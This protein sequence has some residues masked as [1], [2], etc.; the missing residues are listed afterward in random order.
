MKVILFIGHHKVGSTSLQDFLAR[1]SIALARAGILYPAT[2]FES[3]S[4][5]LAS[6]L[7]DELVDDLP[8][9]AR[10]PHNAL[11]FKLMAEQG[12]WKMPPYHKGLPGS[13]QMLRSIRMQAEYLQPHTVILAAE[14]FANFG[15]VAPEMI[16]R[17]AG[18]L[19]GAEL[20]VVATFRRID[21]YLASW[22]GQRLRFGAPALEPLR[23]QG[24]EPYFKGVHFD[25][26][27]MLE[28]WQQQMPEARFILRDYAEVRAAGGA[29]ADFIAQTGLQL[30]EG[31]QPERKTN[32]SFHR[33]IFEIARLGNRALTR[34]QARYLRDVLAGI[35]PQLD[36]PASAD[37]DLFGAENRKILIDRFEPIDAYLGEVAGRAGF[38]PDLQEARKPRPVPEL[39]VFA[40]AA[41]AARGHAKRIKD[42]EIRAFLEGLHSE[43]V[44]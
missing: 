22:F 20:T 30:P 24:M 34:D 15:G 35:T 41:T 42:R 6:A 26:R 5:M 18:L 29:V 13:S 33:G 8:I 27:L 16:E 32:E 28:P 2:D 1:N 11:G 10:E 23:D 37:I 43:A 44:T 7:Q 31:L 38:F 39:E 14:V 21:E 17:L 40:R 4:V 3:L 25:Y 36:L 12:L 9:N 19:P